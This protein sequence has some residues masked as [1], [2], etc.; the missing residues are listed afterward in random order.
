VTEPPGRGCQDHHPAVG[1]RQGRCARARPCGRDRA[2]YAAR[3]SAALAGA[4]R[5]ALAVAMAASSGA[6]SWRPRPG[7]RRPGP[8]PWT[9][10]GRDL[11]PAAVI[12]HAASD[13]PC[14]RRCAPSVPRARLAPVHAQR[15][16]AAGAAGQA[17]ASRAPAASSSAPIPGWPRRAAPEIALRLS[18]EEPTVLWERLEAAPAAPTGAAFWA[19]PWP[20]AS[21]WALPA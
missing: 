12:F 18:N 2:T 3:G 16:T 20:A 7:Q 13:A 1:A 6:A 9:W 21:R 15:P 17:A 11:G 5:A 14:A 10:R 19:Y 8:S 4:V